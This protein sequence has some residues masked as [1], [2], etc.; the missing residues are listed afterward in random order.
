MRS[1]FINTSALSHAKADTAAPAAKAIEKVVYMSAEDSLKN[2]V[3]NVGNAADA[4]LR[5]IAS[6][7]VHLIIRTYHHNDAERRDMTQTK[8]EI[9][10]AFKEYAETKR[11]RPFQNAW[12][13]R[14][15]QNSV[16]MARSLTKD[17]DKKGVQDGSPLSHVLR[18]KT[19]QA[20][21]EIV[22]AYIMGKTKGANAF[23]AL[24]KALAPAKRPEPAA[25]KGRTSNAVKASTDKPNRIAKAIEGDKGAEIFNAI[26]GNAKSKATK[27]ADKVGQSNV[28]HL[29][30]VMRSVGY[31]NTAEDCLAVS[32]AALERMKE[33]EKAATTKPVKAT[34]AAADRAVG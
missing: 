13:S 33:L 15:L 3:L 28:D 23:A 34:E 5:L 22:F 1:Y 31:L 27:L 7:V 32:N 11:G 21:N 2:V 20:G 29:T 26:P 18:A 8:E 30:F 4:T 16:A 25:A 19:A 12:V 14:L 10:S 17:Y 6:M 24:E 9:M